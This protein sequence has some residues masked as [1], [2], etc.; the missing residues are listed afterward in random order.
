MPLEAKVLA[1]LLCSAGLSY[2]NASRLIGGLSNVA[3]HD[4]FI[5]LRGLFQGLRGSIGDA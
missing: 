3:V 1:A 2:R 5:A 4:A